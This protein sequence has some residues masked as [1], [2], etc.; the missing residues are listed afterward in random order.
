MER[1]RAESGHKEANRTRQDS[2]NNSNNSSS[3]NRISIQTISPTTRPRISR[4]RPK[5][6]RDS[7]TAPRVKG[8]L[9]QKEERNLARLPRGHPRFSPG[10]KAG[11]RNGGQSRNPCRRLHRCQPSLRFRDR[12]TIPI[13]ITPPSAISTG[14]TRSAAAK[15]SNALAQVSFRMAQATPIICPWIFPSAPTMF[16]VRAT[17]W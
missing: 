8:R 1:R 15:R 11:A 9:A 5:A 3:S 12:L 4:L 7:R 13:P 17:A 10:N 2:A 14:N 6:G 16:S